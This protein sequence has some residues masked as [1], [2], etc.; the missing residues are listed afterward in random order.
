MKS[1]AVPLLVLIGEWG[2]GAPSL[3]LAALESALLRFVASALS[4]KFPGTHSL[5]LKLNQNGNTED[6]VNMAFCS[7]W[8]LQGGRSWEQVE[9]QWPIR[10]SSSSAKHAMKAFLLL[11]SITFSTGGL[12]ACIL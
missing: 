10:T 4:R 6:E 12:A 3:N 11:G 2:C 1:K 7:T 8:Y 9:G 5:K